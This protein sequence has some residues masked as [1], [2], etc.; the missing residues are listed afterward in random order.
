MKIVASL[1]LFLVFVA[2]LQARQIAGIEMPDATDAAGVPLVLN[3]AGVRTRMF[4]TDAA[5]A[6]ESTLLRAAHNY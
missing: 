3:G 2:P 5:D 6:D 1:I 4:I